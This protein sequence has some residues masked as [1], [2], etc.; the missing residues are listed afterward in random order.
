MAN[1]FQEPLATVPD[2][3]TVRAELGKR[4]RE[5]QLLRRLLRLAEA[6]D[7]ERKPSREE[8]ARG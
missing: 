8:P 1:N 2:A 5:L 4:L 3:R 7:R 6:V